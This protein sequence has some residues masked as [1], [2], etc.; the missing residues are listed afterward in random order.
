MESRSLE[1]CRI[2]QTHINCSCMSTKHLPSD[3]NLLSLTLTGCDCNDAHCIISS[4]ETYQIPTLLARGNSQDQAQI[5]RMCI[6]YHIKSTRV[7]VCKMK[8]AKYECWVVQV[9]TL[10]VVPFPVC[11]KME[12]GIRFQI[13]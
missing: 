10:K 9:L 1:R 6:N 13:K 12:P 5:N 4:N 11:K 8:A 3:G 2:G 7:Q